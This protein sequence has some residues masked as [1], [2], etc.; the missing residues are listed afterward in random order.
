MLDWNVRSGLSHREFL[1]LRAFDR[2]RSF[3]V[4]HWWS[5]K[6]IVVQ[7]TFD[8]TSFRSNQNS[9][10]GPS[11]I[12]K[13]FWV[14]VREAGGRR[15]RP[16]KFHPRSSG[17]CHTSQISV[18][19]SSSSTSSSLSSPSTRCF[20]FCCR[21]RCC[22]CCCL[23]K[24]RK[25]DWQ[26]RRRRWRTERQHPVLVFFFLSLRTKTVFVSLE[27]NQR[28]WKGKCCYACLKIRWVFFPHPSCL[29]FRFRR[30]SQ[31][32]SDV[33]C[34]FSQEG[35]KDQIFCCCRRRLDLIKRWDSDC[36]SILT[37]NLRKTW[38][39]FQFRFQKTY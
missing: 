18:W 22:C 30:W 27:S 34:R 32:C 29:R 8:L 36:H 11:V 3:S 12:V 17:E 39:T 1:P 24:E 20:G 15:A 16:Q 2:N 35:R 4:N 23:Q 38:S 37:F 26:K 19:C 14:R 10:T 9:R 28:F 25:K 5:R 33:E 7:K 6:N 13:N 21:R 31:S